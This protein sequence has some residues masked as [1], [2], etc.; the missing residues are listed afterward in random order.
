MFTKDEL[1]V[2]Y[3]SLN[4]SE[5]LIISNLIEELLFMYKK[6]EECK[7]KPFLDENGKSTGAYQ[8]YKTLNASVNNISKVL[9]NSARQIEDDKANEL[10]AKLSE[11]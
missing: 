11:F 3:D 10:L 9:I 7:S 8:V 4:E 1:M 2:Y 5:K 6:C